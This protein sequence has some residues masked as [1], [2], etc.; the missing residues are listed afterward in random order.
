[1]N[2]DQVDLFMFVLWSWP[3]LL[4]L[5]SSLTFFIKKEMTE[6]KVQ[7]QEGLPQKIISAFFLNLSILT[8]GISHFAVRLP[9][10]RIL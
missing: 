1:M 2:L 9:V 5:M 10:L 7:L 4:E 3:K 8:T 6:C